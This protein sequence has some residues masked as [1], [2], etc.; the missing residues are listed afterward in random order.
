MEWGYVIGPVVG[1]V[2]AA[3]ATV[4]GLTLTNRRDDRIRREE[5]EAS[6]HEQL[7]QGM[8]RYL[9][10]IDSVTAEMPEDAPPKPEPMWIDPY[11]TKVA[12][13]MSLDVAGFIAGRLLQRALYGS[14]PHQ[15][16]DQLAEAASH[17]RLIAPP[18][19]EA[20]MVEADQLR[21]RYKAH[22]A[23][24]LEEWMAFRRRMRAG[25]KDILDA[26]Y[27]SAAPRS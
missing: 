17:L 9:A 3:G 8:S 6:R 22:D 7:R 12:E 23:K 26:R 24:W 13:A 25:F 27:P 20:F 4:A 18:E 15:L 1:A 16:I 14:R 10:A 2:I 11:L 19:V 21:K 5:R